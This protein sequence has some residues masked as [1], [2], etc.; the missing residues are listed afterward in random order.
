MNNIFLL[1]DDQMGDFPKDATENIDWSSCKN[2]FK[3]VW[4]VGRTRCI[5]KIL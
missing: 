2:Y 3:E 5:Y 4:Y 1:F